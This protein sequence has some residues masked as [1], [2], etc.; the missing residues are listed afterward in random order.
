MR[1]VLAGAL[2]WLG[3]V[4]GCN[5]EPTYS[6]VSFVTYN[7]TPWDLERV[8]IVDASGR[9]AATGMVPSGGGEGSI[10]CCYTLKGT[11]FV[12]K[13]KGGDADLMR[14]HMYDGKFDEGKECVRA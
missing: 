11:E 13:R 5:G 3:L 14:K 4:A 6:D 12:V 7:Y 9:V 2:L 8:Q 1:K 10:S